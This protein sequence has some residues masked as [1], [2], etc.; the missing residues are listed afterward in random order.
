[1]S[2][3]QLPEGGGGWTAARR[4]QKRED[5]SERERRHRRSNLEH[6]AAVLPSSDSRRL[7]RPQSVLKIE[8]CVS[9]VTEA[10]IH[11]FLKTT[12]QE[13]ADANR[14]RRRQA[15]PSDVALQ[16]ASERV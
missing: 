13:I 15:V 6:A 16:H 4:Y 9:D 1:M 3:R 11:I 12:P 2:E 14:G 8:A 5:R 10:P 7:D